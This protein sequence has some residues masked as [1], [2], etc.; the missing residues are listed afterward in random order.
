MNKIFELLIIIISITGCISQ[1]S[2]SVDIGND[3]TERTIEG[4]QYIE[5]EYATPGMNG[6][7]YSITHKGNC[8]NPVHRCKCNE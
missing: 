1:T 4:C 5:Y 8:T 3:F 6:Y 2:G 7:V